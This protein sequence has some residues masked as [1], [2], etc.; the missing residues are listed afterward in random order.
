MVGLEEDV[1]YVPGLEVVGSYGVMPF[2]Q[3]SQTK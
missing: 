1:G 2:S 3:L